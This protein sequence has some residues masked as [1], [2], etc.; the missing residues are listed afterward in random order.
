MATDPSAPLLWHYTS[1][2]GLYGI[3]VEDQLMASS[4]AYRNDTE[5]FGYTTKA[6]L[7]FLETKG[8]T[9]AD[10][11]RGLVFENPESLVRAMFTYQLPGDRHYA[12]C[13]S[14]ERDDLSQWRSYTPQPPGFAIGFHPD[15]LESLANS[16][17]FQLAE[18]AYPNETELLYRIEAAYN[19]AT[20]GM[21]E[22]KARTPMLWSN[23]IIEK[24]SVN[25]D[26][27][28]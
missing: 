2:R 1:F 3:V 7:K 11:A 19:L 20:E 6:L 24:F 16:H 12:T 8:N 14:Q 28:S 9:F 4:M 18:C 17:D 22:E 25:G 13:F 27:G 23:E 26:S 5:E 15:E 10:M 21:E